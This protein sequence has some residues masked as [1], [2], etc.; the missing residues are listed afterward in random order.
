LQETIAPNIQ[1]Q[2]TGASAGDYAEAYTR[3]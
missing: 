2:K 3:F 1:I